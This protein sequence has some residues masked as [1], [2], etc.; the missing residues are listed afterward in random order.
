MTGTMVGRTLDW[1]VLAAQIG[2]MNVF[3]IS[4]GRVV[5]VDE[6]TVRLPVG[7]GY[8]VEIFLDASDTYT[9]RRVFTRAG[10]RWVKG[11]QENVYCDEVGEVA[12]QASSF[13]SYDFPKPPAATAW[14][15]RDETTG[16]TGR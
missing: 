5:R 4:G 12:Y 1:P 3:A 7:A 8:S 13:R 9:V 10:Q 11:E 6:S 14:E 15:H 16:W 2:R